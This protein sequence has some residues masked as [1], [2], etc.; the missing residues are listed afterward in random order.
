MSDSRMF[1]SQRSP[2]PPHCQSSQPWTHIQDV[3]E[4][5]D[6]SLEHLPFPAAASIGADLDSPRA[7]M[8][9]TE[10]PKVESED[11]EVTPDDHRKQN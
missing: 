6:S 2:S 7:M 9:D 10:L 4:V 3:I 1:G 5:E 11:D 8:V